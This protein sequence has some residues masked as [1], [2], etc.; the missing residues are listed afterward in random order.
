MVEVTAKMVGELRAKTGAGLVDCKKA[1]QECN[2]VTEEAI[3]WLK[4][5]G[6]LS[7]AKKAGREAQE[8]LIHS[9]IHMG[10][11]LGVLIEV[12][13]ETD[14][15]ARNEEFKQ[16]V[17]DIALHIAALAPSYLRREDVPQEVIDKEMDIAKSQCEGKPA[18]AIEKIVEG[19]M[20]KWYSENCLLEQ[21]FV[22][23]QNQTI[24]DLLNEKIAKIG[25]NIVVKRF[26]RYQLGA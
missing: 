2:G 10:G 17:A 24:Q 20:K 18:A 26:T 8:G 23:N 22:K 7:A 16:M 9:Y 11:K 13:C 14:F 15:V 25:E 3:T 5:K 4:K 12:N 1:L 19:K 6:M 21:A